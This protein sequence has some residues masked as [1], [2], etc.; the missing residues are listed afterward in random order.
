MAKIANPRK[1]FNFSI[2]F[3]QL[4]IEPFLF[5]KVDLPDSEIEVVEHGD[6]NYDVK[7][8]GRRKIGNATLEKL[9]TTTKGSANNYFWDWHDSIANPHIGG[10]LPPSAYWRTMIVEEFGEDG[11]TV[12][13][14]WVC[15]NTWPSKINGQSHE[16]KSS[17]NTIES[18][19][20]VVEKV[21]KIY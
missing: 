7:T 20:M 14:R 1:A 3:P 8:G 5:Q 2:S 6:T 9:L 13:N 12:I 17:D 21:D 11:L 18:I 16:R 4:P 19:E 10:G 15:T